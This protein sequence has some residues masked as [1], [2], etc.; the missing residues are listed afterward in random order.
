[1]LDVFAREQSP[2]QVRID[3]AGAT[4]EL[5]DGQTLHAKLE[6]PDDALLDLY[7]AAIAAVQ[8]FGWVLDRRSLHNLAARPLRAVDRLHGAG[9]AGQREPEQDLGRHL[10]SD[11]V[12]PPGQRRAA[13]FELL[14][15][16]A[17]LG[18]TPASVGPRHRADPTAAPS[19]T[20][21]PRHAAAAFLP[22]R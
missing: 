21:E 9:R 14:G 15:E 22:G 1:V 20:A 12:G 18:R 8:H 3:G 13:A 4:P 19:R 6:T 5:T 16:H 2:F 7:L 11:G 10:V 17:L